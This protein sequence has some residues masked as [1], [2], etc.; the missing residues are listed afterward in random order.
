MKKPE[1]KIYTAALK[2]VLA[3]CAILLLLL[4]PH[5]SIAKKIIKEKQTVYSSKRE[6][7][8]ELY[9][10]GRHYILFA[11]DYCPHCRSLIARMKKANL[12]D[13]VIILDVTKDFAF[14]MAASIEI[15]GVP[16]VITADTIWTP[17][18]EVQVKFSKEIQF[19]ADACMFYLMSALNTPAKPR[20]I[21]EI[22]L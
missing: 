7:V 15:P 13:R 14:S 9:K 1:N 6:M 20:S 12:I 21:K 11:G 10:S 8:K 17:A 4:I 3:I 18:G 5:S 19:G 2:W 22:G 16:A